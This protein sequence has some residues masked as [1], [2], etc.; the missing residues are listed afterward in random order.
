MNKYLFFAS[1]SGQQQNSRVRQKEDAEADALEAQIRHL[2]QQNDD[3]QAQFEKMMKERSD[4]F[5][6]LEEAVRMCLYLFF[7]ECC[8]DG[9]YSWRISAQMSYCSKYHNLNFA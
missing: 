8:P 9:L 1:F 5:A 2:V 7:L 3:K 4:K 6:E